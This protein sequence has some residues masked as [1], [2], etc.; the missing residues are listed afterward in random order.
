[1]GMLGSWSIRMVFRGGE[2]D[3]RKGSRGSLGT[4]V[5]SMKFGH[6]S[7]NI[8]PLEDSYSKLAN[9]FAGYT[10]GKSKNIQ[11]KPNVVALDLP[12]NLSF[13]RLIFQ[14]PIAQLIDFLFVLA[15]YNHP[16]RPLL[17]FSHPGASQ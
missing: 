8:E 5:Y 7:W 14:N 3:L 1:M 10:N 11:P 12:V 6:H 16:I 4:K 9:N 2:M 13:S 15:S 17:F